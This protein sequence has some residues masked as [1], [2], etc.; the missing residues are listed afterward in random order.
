MK[1]PS[2]E[3]SCSSNP[4]LVKI[5]S[6][7]NE[8]KPEQVYLKSNK[9]FKWDCLTCNHIYNQSP[10][11]K[12]SKK[13]RCPYCSNPPQKLCEDNNCEECFNKT[14]YDNHQLEC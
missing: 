13:A 6:T 11:T 14:L 8:L 4:E 3:K 12:N 5:W 10:D 7:E 9:I 2:F 1:I